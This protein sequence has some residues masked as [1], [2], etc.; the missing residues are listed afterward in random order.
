M[1]NGNVLIFLDWN[2]YWLVRKEKF[3]PIWLEK[4]YK[5]LYNKIKEQ[6]LANSL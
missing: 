6:R 5:W 2:I 1:V 3:I 4:S